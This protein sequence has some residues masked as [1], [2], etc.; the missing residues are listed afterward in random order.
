MSEQIDY[1]WIGARQE[2]GVPLVLGPSLSD[3]Q[4]ETSFGNLR[5]SSTQVSY[6]KVEK[7]HLEHFHFL[8]PLR[9]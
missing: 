8:V 1:S 2:K 7:T 6:Q 5:A 3:L 4:S 9:P